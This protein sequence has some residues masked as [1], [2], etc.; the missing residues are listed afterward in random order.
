[1]AVLAAAAAALVP[2]SARGDAGLRAQAARLAAHLAPETAPDAAPDAAPDTGPDAATGPDPRDV[3]HSLAT[4]RTALPDRAVVV[5]ADRAE[6]LAGLAAV[7]AGEPAANVVTGRAAAG[8][9][10]AF[11][12][13]G[14]GGQ[15]AGMGGGLRDAAPFAEAFDEACAHLDPLLGRSLADAVR[16][17]VGLER[18]GIAQ[19][20][21]FAL[22]TAL[23]RLLERW[24]L[25]PD[26]L[27]GHSVGEIAAAHVSGVLS[28]ADAAA[29]VA[30]RA[31][32]MDALPD[33]GSMA[34]LGIGE[35]A[36]RAF[37]ADPGAGRVDVAAVNGPD[38][39]VVA[40]R[41]AD[42]DALAAAVAGRGHRVRRLPVGHAFHS[43]LM[44][45]MLDAFRD[46]V[47]GLEFGEPRIPIVSTRTGRVAS[48]AELADPEHWV[49]HV[50]DTVLF[51]RAVETLRGQGVG[52]FVEL[53]PDGALTGAT[54]DP[55][56]VATLRRGGDDARG[57]LTAVATAHTLG[58]PVDWR[59][60]QGGR[61]IELPTYPF[62]RDRHWLDG[63]A[64]RPDRPGPARHRIAWRPLEAPP[65]P[66]AGAADAGSRTWL[67]V[68][69]SSH[70]T[71]PWTTALTAELAGGPDGDGFEVRRL[72]LPAD[73][74]DAALA[75][76]VAAALDAGPPAGVLSLLALDERPHPGHPGLP[77]GAAGTLALIRVLGAAGAAAPLWAA[78]RGA[79]AVDERE[80]VTGPRQARIWGIGQA[81][82]VE[83]PGRWGGLVDLPAG[84]PAGLGR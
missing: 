31:R 74:D 33:G 34:A 22:E 2:L 13:A 72:V 16:D 5:G 35:E 42:V 60:F 36:L 76:P 18:T 15:Y 44:D 79:V 25:V 8:V 45:P 1:I 75:G 50:R 3:A 23:Y 61:E 48:A 77:A 56:A 57:V 63:A 9:R 58:A 29:L 81:A 6:L 66:P 20:A 69:P 40:G 49:R 27:A 28:L 64:P 41:T 10:T 24:G 55:G 30:A 26:Y 46:A 17:G 37:L 52:V 62:R 43:A 80:R 83:H 65:E 7:A 59:A 51:H 68:V 82:G 12:F 71:D 54:G 84:D 19:P 32:L 73:A 21:L 39:V 47:A 67:L 53:G 14:Q 70:E 11:L 38:A 78:T 4:T